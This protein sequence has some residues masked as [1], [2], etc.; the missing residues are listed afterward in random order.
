MNLDLARNRFEAR[1]Q[2]FSQRVGAVT[3]DRPTAAA[4]G[5]IESEC[6]DDDSRPLDSAPIQRPEVCNLAGAIGQ[7]VKHG[8]V[9]P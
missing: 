5:S 7:K 1:P 9:M 8:A 3:L 6:C 4:F 2:S